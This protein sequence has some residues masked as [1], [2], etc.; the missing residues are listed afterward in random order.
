DHVSFYA[1]SSLVGTATNSP[2][3]VTWSNPPGG[4]YL[5]TAAATD[6][7]GHVT[8]S[9]PVSVSVLAGTLDPPTASPASGIV[10]PSQTVS[11]SAA[12]G[13]TIHY[14]LD[15]STPSA[16]SPTYAAPLSFTQPT[17]VKAQAYETYWSPSTVMTITYQIDSTPPTITTTKSP[18]PNA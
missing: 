11:L 1:S 18:T 3:Q 7:V 6:N 13:T 15:G 17:T 10:G 4:S 9:P 2:Y 8:T 14:T 12:A 16:S 5:L